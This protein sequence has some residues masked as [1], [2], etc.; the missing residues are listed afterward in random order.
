MTTSPAN[1]TASDSARREAKQL[2]IPLEHEIVQLLQ[3]LVR[4]NS[5][6]IPP[7]G[8]ETEAQKVL[9]NFLHTNN[10]EAEMYDIGFLAEAQH[11][12]V[13]TNRHYS[14][15]H[16]LIARLSGSGRGKRLMV[17]GQM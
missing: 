13:R 8:S 6:A 15:R 2:L 7:N 10:V 11:P 17:S 14:G 5:V 4:T 3:Q 16:N 1:S 9:L 12:Y